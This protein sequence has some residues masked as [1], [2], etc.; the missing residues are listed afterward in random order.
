[1]K[2]VTTVSVFHRKKSLSSDFERTYFSRLPRNRIR[3]LGKVGARRNFCAKSSVCRDDQLSPSPR[4]ARLWR[5]TKRSRDF[6]FQ[7]KLS[8]FWIASSEIENF[9]LAKTPFFPSPRGAR[10][11]R[12]RSGNFRFELNF[13]ISRIAWRLRRQRQKLCAKLKSLKVSSKIWD[14]REK[15]REFCAKNFRKK[16]TKKL[17]ASESR[18]V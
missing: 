1:M 16:T 12:K 13:Q 15:N 9:L 11:G 18:L 17:P 2:N 3:A 14:G 7:S 10:S 5:A 4:G 8:I 6:Q